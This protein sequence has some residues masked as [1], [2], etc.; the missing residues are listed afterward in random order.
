MS[1]IADSEMSKVLESIKDFCS[2]SPYS[3]VLVF[4]V[5]HYFKDN[6]V[7]FIL[8]RVAFY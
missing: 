2:F 4:E 6:F 8:H 7:D 5:I 1:W 3:I